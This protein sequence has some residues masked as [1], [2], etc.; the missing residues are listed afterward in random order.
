MIL[1]V[2]LLINRVFYTFLPLENS[3]DRVD[4]LTFNV[5]VTNI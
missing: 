4:F 1:A 5:H 2:N 3:Y